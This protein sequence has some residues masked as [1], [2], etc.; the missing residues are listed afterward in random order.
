MSTMCKGQLVP[1]GDCM[2]IRNSDN[3]QSDTEVVHHAHQTWPW[4]E[5]P[6]VAGEER[7]VQPFFGL[8]LQ[9]DS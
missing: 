9:S 6:F 8:H 7:Y 1:D 3:S 4:H 2:S 5:T